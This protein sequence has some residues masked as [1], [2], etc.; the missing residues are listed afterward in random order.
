MCE[1]RVV[2]SKEY[3]GESLSDVDRDV[4]E[5]WDSNSNHRMAEIPEEDGIMKGYFTVTITWEPDEGTN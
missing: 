2:F 3:N 5:C 1:Q 4:S